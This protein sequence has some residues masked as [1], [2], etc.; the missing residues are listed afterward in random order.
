MYP[1]KHPSV[2][3]DEWSVRDRGVNDARG[4]LGVDHVRVV[5]S[6][7]EVSVRLLGNVTKQRP[8]LSARQLARC[9][10]GAILRHIPAVGEDRS[11]GVEAVTDTL[12]GVIMLME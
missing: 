3:F 2:V 11:G 1:R 8:P 10:L 7:Y 9:R 6:G 4:V 5:D 12:E